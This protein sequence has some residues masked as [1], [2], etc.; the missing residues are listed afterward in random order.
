[1]VTGGFKQTKTSVPKKLDSTVTGYLWP[2]HSRALWIRH[3]MQLHR[4]VFSRGVRA[5]GETQ[6]ADCQLPGYHL[7][8][9]M[10]VS[11]GRLQGF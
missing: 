1:M 8:T 4:F 3:G 9:R 6:N 11:N 2:I 5:P 10:T 7:Q